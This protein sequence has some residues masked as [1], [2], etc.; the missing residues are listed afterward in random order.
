LKTSN[1]KYGTSGSLEIPKGD[2]PG[3]LDNSYSKTS[4]KLPSGLRKSNTINENMDKQDQDSKG[5]SE[6]DHKPHRATIGSS[7]EH[8]SPSQPD[9][10]NIKKHKKHKSIDNNSINKIEKKRSTSERML[11]DDKQKSE[12]KM[13]EHIKIKKKHSNSYDKD[14]NDKKEK[15]EKKNKS[16]EENEQ[17]DSNS[18]IFRKVQKRTEDNQLNP[19]EV[20]PTTTD[21]PSANGTEQTEQSKP[22]DIQV[23]NQNKGE[24]VVT[25][26]NNDTKLVEVNK[27]IVISEPTESTTT[28]TSEKSEPIIVVTPSQPQDNNSPDLKLNLDSAMLLSDEHIQ[29]K[30]LSAREA[31]AKARQRLAKLREENE[32]AAR[33]LKEIKEKFGRT[34]DT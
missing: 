20:L 24:E 17:E 9:G 8:K 4:P 27:P 25:T 2:L 6:N 29:A 34:V 21:T 5:S 16:I 26:E 11:V 18:F 13:E 12:N 10:E 15:R 7:D 22:T 30:L 1:R 19:T 23:E 32:A 33:R 31:E 14:K 3:I 28:S